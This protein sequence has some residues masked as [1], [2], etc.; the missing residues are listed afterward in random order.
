MT[1]AQPILALDARGRPALS[2]G[3]SFIAHRARVYRW[4]GAH[5]LAH[6]RCLDVVQE[7]FARLLRN[8]PAFPSEAA[9]LGWLR[10]IAVNLAID[11][12]RAARA[13]SA[14][15]I[16]H[17]PDRGPPLDEEER[18][19]L[20]EAMAGLSEMQRLVLVMKTVDGLSFAEIA[21]ELALATPTAKTHYLRA[22]EA[23]RRRFPVQGDPS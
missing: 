22:L 2:P 3:D 16:V 1:P 4:A 5:G 6:D 18:T 9:Q 23:I 10:R 19:R 13:P 20:R 12:G 15:R 17:P 21:A 7:T 8:P 14:L 11:T